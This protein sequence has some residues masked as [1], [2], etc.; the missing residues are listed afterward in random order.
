MARRLLDFDH[1]ARL[2]QSCAESAIGFVRTLSES[3]LKKELPLS[4]KKS[5]WEVYQEP[6]RLIRMFEFDNQEM[7]REFVSNLLDYQEESHHHAKIIV[8]FEKVIVET[9]THDIDAITSQDLD[10]A[11]F[12]DDLYTDIEYYE[13]STGQVHRDNERIS[14]GENRS[15]TVRRRDPR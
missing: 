9:Y 2:T 1:E 14:G 7:L 5:E 4:P 8:E 12:C 3:T 11:K 15:A 6:E 10:L 13:R